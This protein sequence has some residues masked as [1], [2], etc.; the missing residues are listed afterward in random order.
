MSFML[1]DYAPPRCMCVVRTAGWSPDVKH[2][3]PMPAQFIDPISGIL[4]CRAHEEETRHGMKHE[5]T[6]GNDK[7]NRDLYERDLRKR[8]QEHL[9]AVRR[10]REEVKGISF[11]P[12]LH[13]GCSECIGTGIKKDGTPCVH[14]ISC[15][16]PKCNPVF[17]SAAPILP[18]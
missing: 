7:I 9:E 1:L 11:R 6:T 18:R 10:N 14:H 2:Q 15:P 3:C 17:M 8:Q 16:C 5:Y 13:D 12:C 4:I